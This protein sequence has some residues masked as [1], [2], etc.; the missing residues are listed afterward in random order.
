MTLGHEPV[1]RREEVIV[2][3]HP[4]H[5]HEE[6][7]VEDLNFE[8]RQIVYRVTQLVWLLFGGVNGLIG[9]RIILKLIAANPNNAF[10]AF[11][12]KLTNVFL[13]PFVGITGVPSFRNHV[14]EIHSIIAMIVYTLLAWGIV[15][16]I[17]VVF[18]RLPS[19]HI[20]VYDREEH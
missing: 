3:K 20:T 7:V 11:V 12:Y 14:L 8:R 4:D 13:W 15:S 16:L 6:R 9:I 10:A 17:E 2:Q 1:S 19:R 18:Y 5:L